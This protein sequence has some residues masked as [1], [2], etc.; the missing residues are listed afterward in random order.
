[1]STDRYVARAEPGK[2]WRIWNRKTKRSWGN[3]F[4]EHPADVLAELNGPC[5]PEEL[6]RLCRRS[7]SRP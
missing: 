5:R 3:Y 7:Y 6:V 4:K 1:M 2:G